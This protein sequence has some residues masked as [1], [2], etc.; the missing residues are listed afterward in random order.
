MIDYTNVGFYKYKSSIL[1]EAD[2]I[3]EYPITDYI[4]DLVKENIVPL[5]LEMENNQ[6][7]LINGL[8]VI[9]V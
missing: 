4:L 5:E 3:R 6:P 1:S 9:L 7:K 8:T 2:C